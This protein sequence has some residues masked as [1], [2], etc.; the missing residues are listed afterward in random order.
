MTIT[1]NLSALLCVCLLGACGSPNMDGASLNPFAGAAQP[2]PNCD[3]F[4]TSGGDSV[5]DCKPRKGMMPAQRLS[6]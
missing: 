1:K 4:A 5:A 2:D 3:R 6:F